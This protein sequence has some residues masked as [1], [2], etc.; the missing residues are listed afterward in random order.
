MFISKEYAST[1]YLA[2]GRCGNLRRRARAGRNTQHA[3]GCI[4]CLRENGRSS[5]CEADSLTLSPS[6]TRIHVQQHHIG[7]R[8]DLV[9]ESFDHYL[10]DALYSSIPLSTSSFC[11]SPTASSLL[12]SACTTFLPLSP[13]LRDAIPRQLLS[14]FALT[15]AGI[16]VLYFSLATLSYYT[17]FDHRMMTHPRFLPAQIQQ[18]IKVS[19]DSFAPVAF[20]TLPWFLGDV[21]GWSKLYG[22]VAEG[23]FGSEGGYKAGLYMAGV[24]VAFLL[25][26]DF[27]IYFVHKALHHPV[28]SQIRSR[29]VVQQELTLCSSFTF[30]ANLQENT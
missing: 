18:E 25:F 17:L 8:M 2:H 14:L 21:R 27:L 12:Q 24:S 4:R 10:G 3:I 16:F 20:M 13:I 23:P 1:L 5:G 9:L 28:S 19:M 11:T 26:T 6:Y 29:E 30:E 7:S 15:Y 22:S